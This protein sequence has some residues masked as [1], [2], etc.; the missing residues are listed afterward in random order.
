MDSN[1][2]I[3]KGL[4]IQEDIENMNMYDRVRYASDLYNRIHELPVDMF[5][6]E[7][8]LALQRT[9]R[10]RHV[11][12]LELKD[13]SAKELAARVANIPN[14]EIGKTFEEG[15]P[16]LVDIIVSNQFSAE[17]SYRWCSTI[18]IEFSQI[19]PDGFGGET[20]FGVVV[21]WKVVPEWLKQDAKFVRGHFEKEVTLENWV[22]QVIATAKA[23]IEHKKDVVTFCSLSSNTDDMGNPRIKYKTWKTKGRIL[24]ISKETPVAHIYHAKKGEQPSW[25]HAP[26]VH[27]S[28]GTYVEN[29]NPYWC[30][31]VKIKRPSY[32]VA[33][34]IRVYVDIHDYITQSLM[35]EL[36]WGRITHDRL[37]RLNEIL[38][39]AEMELETSDTSEA[40]LFRNFLPIGFT[41]WNEYLDSI[42][43]PKFPK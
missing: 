24:S 38:K 16:Q 13:V 18:K 34:P 8:V 14:C 12:I 30:L 28:N 5:N 6:K 1:E 31:T 3:R 33:E 22:D 35:P 27:G 37:D 41:T 26:G 25:D 2:L 9:L 20:S 40:A 7:S 23:L 36:E 10:V 43:L 29:V 32:E 11:S 4:T 42:I 21:R 15:D 17:I 39:G 19:I